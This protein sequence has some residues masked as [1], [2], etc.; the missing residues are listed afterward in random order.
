MHLLNYCF[1]CSTYCINDFLV[2]VAVVRSQGPYF[3]GWFT[4]YSKYCQAVR[5]LSY[6]ARLSEYVDFFFK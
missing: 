3:F 6:V 2:A 5:F 1:A 4:G